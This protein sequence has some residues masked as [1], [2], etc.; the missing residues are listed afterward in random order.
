[1]LDTLPGC[2]ME[3]LCLAECYCLAEYYRKLCKA[4]NVEWNRISYE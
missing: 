4:W 1:M 2:A 3:H